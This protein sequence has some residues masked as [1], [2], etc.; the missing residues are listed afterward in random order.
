MSLPQ[1]PQGGA[2]SGDGGGK[3][4]GLKEGR[5]QG[6]AEPSSEGDDIFAG[7]A[8]AANV[9][10]ALFTPL[11]WGLD[12]T[13]GRD[14]VEMADVVGMGFGDTAGDQLLGFWGSI[15]HA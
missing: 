12:P 9:L 3:S 2:Q 15:P 6:Q 5:G 11:S 10:A 1:N 13:W 7:G 8:D 14:K 4:G